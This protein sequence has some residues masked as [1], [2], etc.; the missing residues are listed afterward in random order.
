MIRS[1]A[2]DYSFFD[3]AC[4]DCG[5]SLK[6]NEP[7]KKHTTFKIG[8]PATRFVTV[9]NETQLE[10]VVSAANQSNIR[11][12]MLGKGSNLLIDDAGID[13]VVIK[14]EGDFK[15]IRL[16]SPTKI[17]AP[18]GASLAAL[19]RF[20]LEN[21]LTGLEFSWGIPGSVGGAVYMNA[22]AYGGEMKNVVSSASYLLG[23]EIHSA[24]GD[25]LKFSYRKS[26]FTNSNEIILGAEFDL[27][28]GNYD[29]IHLLME[30]L[31]NKRKTKQPYDLPS[32]GSVFKR[33][34][35]YFAAALI[36]ECGLKGASVGGAM[37]SEKHS[38][39]I[40]NSGNSTCNDVVMLIEKIKQTVW[41]KKQVKL[42]CEVKVCK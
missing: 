33:P 2:L 10:K 5:C 37:V 36:E 9:Y 15:E 20:A 28:Q 14:L 26:R 19:G 24:S 41:D 13:A 17:Y 40:I 8:G 7:M 25:D 4:K 42:E 16:I 22:G 31:M 34:D 29:E 27:T 3:F 35:G 39:F 23:S 32:A 6:I 11:I 38:G 18:A 12:F 21:N 30:D 1:S